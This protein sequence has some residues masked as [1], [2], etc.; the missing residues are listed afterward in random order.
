MERSRNCVCTTLD[1]IFEISAFFLT[2][3]D[4]FHFPPPRLMVGT[5]Y[6]FPPLGAA[7][8]SRRTQTQRAGLGIWVPVA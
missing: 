7:L 2:G 8:S 6:I 4:I 3:F 1:D 5:P